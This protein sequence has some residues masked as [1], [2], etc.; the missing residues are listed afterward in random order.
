MGISNLFGLLALLAVPIIIL[1]YMFR[2]KHRLI[3]VPSTFLW[4]QIT[5]QLANAKKFEKL[6]KSI[7]LILD[8][9]IAI[10]ITALL[11]GIFFTSTSTQDHHIILIDGSFSMNSTDVEPSRFERAKEMAKDYVSSLKDDSDITVILLNESPKIIYKKEQSKNIVRSGID[12]LRPSMD[13]ADLSK[14]P[15]VISSVKDARDTKVVYFGDKNIEGADNIVVMGNSNNIVIKNMASKKSSELVNTVITVENQ[16]P[17]PKEVKI[18]LYDDDLY[19]STKAIKIKAKSEEMVFFEN[20]NPEIKVLKAV[21]EDKDDNPYDNTF[22]DVL[23]T[24][25]KTKIALV[26]SGN[27][28]IE[29][30]LEIN[31]NFDVYKISPNEYVKLEGYALYI[32]DSYLPKDLPIDGNILVLDPNTDSENS[33]IKANGYIKNPVFTIEKHPI[34]K[35]IGDRTFSVALSQVFEKTPEKMPIYST[36]EGYLAYSMNLARQKIVVFA[37]DFRFT[38]LPLEPEF[39]ILMNNIMSELTSSKMTD[40]YS[41]ESSENVEV[42]ILPSA[43]FAKIIKPDGAELDIDMENSIYNYDETKSLGLYKI[44]QNLGGDEESIFKTS[45]FA[46]NPPKDKALTELEK[47]E[48]IK[49]SEFKTRDDIDKFLFIILIILLLLELFVRMKTRKTRKIGGLKN[50]N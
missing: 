4:Q 2:P 8:I 20:I 6:K 42:K 3:D 17:V 47:E 37:F 30:Y 44:V 49:T 19:L 35:F 16:S 33:E 9:L 50:D 43:L 22:Y 31:E 7:L 27:L 10:F 21:L 12:K 25:E 24:Q 28:F 40:K 14:I 38:D 23:S 34:N 26:T 29:K 18:S 39:P 48:N 41:Y 11:L 15:S 46:V 36:Q 5:E 45:Y 1:L 13:T 32:F